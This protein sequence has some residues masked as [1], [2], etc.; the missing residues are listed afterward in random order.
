MEFSP[1]A[2]F[3][4]SEDFDWDKPGFEQTG[5]S[6]VGCVSFIDAQAYVNWLSD[7]TGAAYRL[8]SEAE[9]EFC[10]SGWL[11]R[12]ILLGIRAD[13]SLHLRQCAQPRRPHH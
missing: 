11:D 1:E 12:A 7:E 4:I 8:P 6:P 10:R 13:G 3:T 9:W 5:N 2:S